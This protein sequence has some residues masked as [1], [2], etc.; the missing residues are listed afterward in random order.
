M[1]KIILCLS[2]LLSFAALAEPFTRT[3]KAEY[4]GLDPRVFVQEEKRTRTK[5]SHDGITATRIKPTLTGVISVKLKEGV[6]AEAFI[7]KHDLIIQRVSRLNMVNA[8]PVETLNLTKLADIERFFVLANQLKA[9]DNV[10]WVQMGRAD[11][12]YKTK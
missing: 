11:R 3:L 9:S 8:V 1:K 4:D 6:D 10:L 12:R 7:Q 2:V 5:V